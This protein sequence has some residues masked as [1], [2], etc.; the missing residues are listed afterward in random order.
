M[1][2]EVRVQMKEVRSEGE[3]RGEVERVRLHGR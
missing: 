1:E 2:G 3:R